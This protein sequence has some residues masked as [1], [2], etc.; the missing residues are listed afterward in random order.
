MFSKWSWLLQAVCTL[1]S[2][3]SFGGKSAGLIIINCSI[4][5]LSSVS[6]L[7]CIHY[8]KRFLIF[9]LNLLYGRQRHRDHRLVRSICVFLLKPQDLWAR[10]RC[11][12]H[13]VRLHSESLYLFLVAEM[14]QVHWKVHSWL[15][16]T[17]FISGA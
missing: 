10:A 6:L 12:R 4:V 8:R 7:I 1:L 13:T 2:I 5:L 9:S 16:Q 15:T 11:K 14:N 3:Y 17:F